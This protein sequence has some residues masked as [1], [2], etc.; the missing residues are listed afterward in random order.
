[1][2]TEGSERLVAKD[3]F[4]F[5]E[6]EG[7]RISLPQPFVEAARLSGGKPVDRLLLLIKPGAYRLLP[8]TG[9]TDKEVLH[10]ILS[11]WDEAGAGEDPLEKTDG[12]KWAGIR[13]RLIPCVVSPRGSGWRINVPRVA[14]QL[15]APGDHF[16]VFLLIVGGYVELWFPDAMRRAVSGTVSS[17]SDGVGVVI[18]D[19]QTWENSRRSPAEPK[20]YR[21]QALGLVSPPNT[22]IA[23]VVGFSPELLRFIQEDPERLRALTPEQFEHFVA[24]L[25][26]RM[27]YEV[28]LTGATNR[29]DGGIDLVAAPKV[30]RVGSVVIA[31]QVK[32]HR[33]RKTER[34]AVDR[35]LAW[36]DSY[37][38]VG[39][40]VTNTAFTK[41][42][43]WTAMQEQNRR[44][45]RLRDF[46]DLKRW[47]EGRFDDEADWRET[48]SHVELAP[49]VIVEIPRPNISTRLDPFDRQR[50]RKNAAHTK[51]PRDGSDS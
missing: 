49:G 29:K 46:T 13:A 41:D 31:G 24:E 8:E 5:V 4:T 15:V 44:F 50:S 38:G 34:E 12:D 27:G 28:V 2:A 20:K 39:L 48:P 42:A 36:K 25:L 1:M 18:T 9:S 17:D 23:R 16:G 7:G 30:A 11:Q 3:V 37:F 45:L 10:E 33:D 19:L 22:T 35:L 14:R 32:H 51:P 43:V 6:L 47:L 40:L 26:D 21:W